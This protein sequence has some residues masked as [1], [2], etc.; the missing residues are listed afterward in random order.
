M[1][2][3]IM[4]KENALLRV[5]FLS[6]MPCQTIAESVPSPVTIQKKAAFT[7]IND[8]EPNWV[9]P[10]SF[11]INRLIKKPMPV[12]IILKINPL[13]KNFTILV[14]ANKI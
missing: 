5:N 1:T 7:M 11:A 12:K 8:K 14:S 4:V 10:A 3:V 6:A 13:N 2:A 9:A